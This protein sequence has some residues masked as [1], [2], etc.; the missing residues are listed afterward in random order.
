MAID[1]EPKRATSA[2]V[3][4]VGAAVIIPDGSDLSS[5]QRAAACGLYLGIEAGASSAGIRPLG[6]RLGLRPF[7]LSY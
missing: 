2:F 1:T 6:M 4:I 5:A 7:H 3:A